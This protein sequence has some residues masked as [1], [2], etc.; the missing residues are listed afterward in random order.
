MTLD[1]DPAF[2]LLALF[3]LVAAAWL[4]FDQRDQWLSLALDALYRIVLQ[5]PRC[6]PGDCYCRRGCICM[7]QEGGA[8]PPTANRS[9]GILP[10]LHAED[11]Q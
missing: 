1:L 9:S 2:L 8:L 11:V 5:L 4:I 7:V 3:A 6:T 10:G